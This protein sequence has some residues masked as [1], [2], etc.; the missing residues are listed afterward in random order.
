[1]KQ[2]CLSVVNLDPSIFNMQIPFT[3]SC[4]PLLFHFLPFICMHEHVPK[5]RTNFVVLF[6]D[7]V[8]FIAHTHTHFYI[9]HHVVHFDDSLIDFKSTTFG[10]RL[11]YE[12]TLNKRLNIGSKHRIT[13]LSDYQPKFIYIHIIYSLQY[14]T[15]FSISFHTFCRRISYVFAINYYSLVAAC[16]STV[17]SII[18]LMIN[19]N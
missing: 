10:N 15:V 4:Y 16:Y 7:H 5:N 18:R 2:K 19:S 17:R 3:E 1:M 11:K 8:R 14:V 6:S 9:P 12:Q 13:K